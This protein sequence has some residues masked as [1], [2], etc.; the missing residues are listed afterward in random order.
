M[1]NKGQFYQALADSLS[2][3]L[4]S[5]SERGVIDCLNVLLPSA[6]PVDLS[7]EYGKLQL[8]FLFCWLC[9]IAIV[10]ML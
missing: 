3:R 4:M 10:S 6:W 1:I 5:E 9:W 2:Q 8:L 7:P